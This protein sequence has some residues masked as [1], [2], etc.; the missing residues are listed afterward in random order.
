MSLNLS[1]S[2]GYKILTPFLRMKID[3]FLSYL[4]NVDARIIVYFSFFD[5][6]VMVCSGYIRNTFTPEIPSLDSKIK[7]MLIDIFKT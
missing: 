1:L 6:H 5:D 4:R 7:F 2:I 3:R